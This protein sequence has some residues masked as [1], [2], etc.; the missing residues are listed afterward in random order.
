M[1][2]PGGNLHLARQPVNRPNDR[3]LLTPE[4]ASKALGLLQRPLGPPAFG[5]TLGRDFHD[6][7]LTGQP[8]QVRA[9]VGFGANLMMSQADT[10]RARAALQALDFQVHCDL[11]ETPT[12]RHADYLLPVNT[13][14]E[15]E[16]LR[17]GFEISAAA[18]EHIQL[19]QPIVAQLADNAA[20]SDLDIVFA[21]ATRLGL[22]EHFFGGDVQAGWN[23]VL[24]PLGLTVEQLRAH[25]GGL[26]V[27]VAQAM[28]RYADILPDGTVRGFA[29]PSR[30]V[31]FYAAQ[32][33]AHGYAPVPFAQEPLDAV[34]LDATER[35]GF[36]LTLGCA[37]SGYFCQ[38]Q[39]RALASLR[40]RE[41]EPHVRLHPGLAETRGIQDGDW[42][43]VL[44]RNGQARYRARLDDALAP[45]V[46]MA[47]FGWW[48][49]CEDLG[50]VGDDPLAPGNSHFNGLIS[51]EHLD[52]VSGAI[53][54]RAF[55]CNITRDASSVCTWAGWKA[56]EVRAVEQVGGDVIVLELAAQDGGMLPDY[57]CGQF[58]P[59]ALEADGARI[60]RSYSLIGATRAQGHAAYRIAVKRSTVP[61]GVSQRL[62]AAFVQPLQARSD[63]PRLW[64][65]APRGHLLLPS[66]RSTPVV[67]M[68]AGVGITPFVGMLETLAASPRHCGAHTPPILLLYGNRDGAHHAFAERLRALAARLPCLQL[69]VVYSRPLARDVQGRDYQHQ[70]HVG[71]HL[72]PQGWMDRQARFYLCGP[73]AMLR[74]VQSGLL[75]RGAHGFAIFSERFQ[76]PPAAQPPSE[77]P[78]SV[79]FARSGVTRSWTPAAGSL[80]SLAA[81]HGLTLPSG[82]RIGQCESCLVRVRSGAVAHLAPVDLSEP[83]CCLAC[84]AV[85]TTDLVLE[86]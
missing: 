5:W 61:E 4:Q 29:T 40:R 46:V 45:E 48:Q 7:V 75:A 81:G 55:P 72:V 9:L 44:T 82:C 26:R 62:H 84:V 33:H 86:A 38:S 51:T 53:A 21:L 79:T 14:W 20:R 3:Q 18:E 28:R 83:G 67:L 77:G 49:A 32:F 60:E 58:V 65:Q 54:L 1:D 34:A 52:D 15:R 66:Q 63:A 76:A 37:K 50:L 68:A 73:E 23:H 24:A 6:A 78:F 80:L 25:P 57:L 2:G 22:G 71:A 43:L 39:H 36:P 10:G 35:H 64:L 85:P 19:R 16:A 11:F 41:P 13:P 69:V 30:R 27:P 17:I 47:S 42:C 70:G 31:E 56:F 12:A 8:Y 59:L 74:D